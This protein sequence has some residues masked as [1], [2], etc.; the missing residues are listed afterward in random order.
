[1]G[2][3]VTRPNGT[4][5]SSP[6]C[7][8]V[9]AWNLTLQSGWCAERVLAALLAYQTRMAFKYMSDTA[10]SSLVLY[11]SLCSFSPF[12]IALKENAQNSC[13]YHFAARVPSSCLCVPGRYI[14]VGL[15][16]IY[17]YI[18]MNVKLDSSTM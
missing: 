8:L 15:M 18:N 1:M 3:Y 10:Q 2:T 4:L 6:F 13:W 9:W 14:Q 5:Q 12:D 17:F 11:H 16:R 7:D